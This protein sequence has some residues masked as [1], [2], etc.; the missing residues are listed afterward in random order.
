MQVFGDHYGNCVYLFE[1][2]C[3][4]Q[5]RHQKI[6]EEAP[7]PNIPEETRRSIG[8]AAVRAAQAVDYVGAGTV[9]FILDAERH[10]FFFMEMNTR[11]QVE[12][13]V[14]EMITGT[15]LVAWQLKVAAGEPL[16]VLQKDL[17]IRGHSFE[18]RVYAENPED[19]FMPGAGPLTHLSLNFDP[20][21]FDG[22]VRVESGVRQGDQVSVHYDPMI[23]KLVVWGE[24]RLSALR[25]L[26]NLLG[27]YHVSVT[28]ACVI[29]H[30]F[31]LPGL[32][33]RKLFTSYT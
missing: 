24:D 27:G 23:A 28:Y 21:L 10:E 26:R 30:T 4:V 5:R 12:H 1:R 29:R 31:Q 8:E 20:A 22:T 13:P 32:A 14:T 3:S 2:D 15:D 19:N 11:L 33:S 25:K 16:P 9:E 6:I 7:A 18:A 17:R